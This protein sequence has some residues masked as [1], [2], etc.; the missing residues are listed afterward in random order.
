MSFVNTSQ[1]RIRHYECDAN[2]WL[3]PP[4][5]LGYLQEAAFDASAVVGWSA[6]R[7]EEVG[8]QWFAYE[9]QM[10]FYHPLRYMDVIEV[11]TWVANFRRVRSLRSY[12]IYREGELVARAATDWVFV[13]ARTGV[14]AQIPPEVVVDYERDK[15][16]NVVEWWK[17]Y[18]PFP[19]APEQVFTMQRR[20]E[21]RDIDPAKHVNNAVYLHYV[22]EAER[23]AGGLTDDLSPTAKRLQ[24]E[25]KLAAKL[26]DDITITCWTGNLNE[27]YYTLTRSSDS[28]LLA[29][30]QCYG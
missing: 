10:E 16:D 4:T 5:L 6:R 7:Y 23:L 28:K 12:E 30:V 2:G 21:L 19:Q 13:N 27:R 22:F 14:L 18:L 24:I 3:R 11:R 1:F 20:V 9:T 26:D 15:P 25:Y 29:R 8:F 17:K